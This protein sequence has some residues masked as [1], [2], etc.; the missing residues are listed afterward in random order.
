MTEKEVTTIEKGVVVTMD[1]SLEVDGK[2]ID[3]GPIQFLHGY[4]NIIP[5]LESEVEG[6]SLGEE[7]A[8]FV[9][10]KE[11]YGVYN[12]ELE[13]DVPLS[14]FPEDFEIKLGHPMRI[15]DGEGNIFTGVAMSINDTSVELNLNHPLAGKDLHFMT[16]VTDLRAATALEKEQGRLSSECSSCSSFDCGEC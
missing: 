8:V 14:S 15:Q 1:Y 10:A 5:G 6:M 9:K 16:K 13:L 4:G 12:P 2:E 11:A 3:S 7:K